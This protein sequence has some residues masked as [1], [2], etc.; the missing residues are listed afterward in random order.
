MRVK[1]VSS[2][3]IKETFD[4]YW[5][6]LEE[7]PVLSFLPPVLKFLFKI[8]GGTV[9]DPAEKDDAKDKQE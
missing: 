4:T 3:F 7:H 2:P 8:T 5:K 9:A 1:Y 6:K